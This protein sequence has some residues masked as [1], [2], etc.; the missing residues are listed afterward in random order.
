MSK[1]EVVQESFVERLEA[2]SSQKVENNKKTKRIHD[3][4]SKE[5]TKNGQIDLE[6]QIDSMIS[7]EQNNKTIESHDISMISPQPNTDKGVLQESQGISKGIQI[8]QQ[9]KINTQ[10]ELYKTNR[11]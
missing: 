10:L 4:T 3:N 9:I 7:P 5:S 2:I 11:I 8:G 6:I 1:F